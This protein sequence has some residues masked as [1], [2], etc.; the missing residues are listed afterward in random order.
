MTATSTQAATSPEVLDAAALISRLAK[1]A[2][3]IVDFTEVRFSPLLTQPVIVSG[4]L[5]YEGPDTLDRRVT[6]PYREDTEIRGNA[7]KVRREG[8]PERS[9]G[10]KRAPELQGLLSAF[11]AL[12]AGDSAAVERGFAI[13]AQGSE[14]AWHV[15][16]IPRDAR[17]SKRVQQI[18]IDGRSDQPRCFWIL[19]DN[20]GASVM[21]LGITSHAELPQPLTREW[22]ERSCQ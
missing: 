15:T 3:A 20:N 17:L 6:S 5:G 18:R 13:S 14:A 2:P 12:L 8:E 10:L 22:L 1:P 19:N 9:F 21:L 7:V 11:T 4:T 16:L